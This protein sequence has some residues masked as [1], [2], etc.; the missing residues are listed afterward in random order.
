MLQK[1]YGA[2]SFLQLI[3]F[4]WPLLRRAAAVVH[5]EMLVVMLLASI[6]L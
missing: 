3:Y 1:M 4:G 2:S 6:Y 5:N